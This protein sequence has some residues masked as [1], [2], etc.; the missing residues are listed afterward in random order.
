LEEKDEINEF[1]SRLVKC[2]S[3]NNKLIE[4][5][6]NNPSIKLIVK[7]D[8]SVK[9]K[10]MGTYYVCGKSKKGSMLET[11]IKKRKI[12]KAFDFTKIERGI[13]NFNN[14]IKFWK[15]HFSHKVFMGTVVTP[16]VLAG[17]KNMR[18]KFNI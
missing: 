1:F 2:F 4:Y 12:N 5:F 17:P 16:V 11:F 10:S 7:V 15:N 14:E 13:I 18:N 6:I 8:L 9:G 3:R